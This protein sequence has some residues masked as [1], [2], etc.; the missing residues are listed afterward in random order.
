VG[1]VA[2]FD[3]ASPGLAGILLSYPATDG[4]LV[5]PRS[6]IERAHDAGALVVMVADILSLTLLTPPGEFGADIAVGSTQR[7][8]VPLGFGGPHAAYLSTRSEHARRVP[9]RIVGVS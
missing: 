9:G 1:A 4:R 3:F 2:D 8:G 6:A 7:F 5:D